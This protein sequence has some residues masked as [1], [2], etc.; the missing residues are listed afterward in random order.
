M[1]AN[2]ANLDGA[3][4]SERQFGVA[5]LLALATLWCFFLRNTFDPERSFAIDMDNEFFIGTVLSAISASLSHGEWPLRMDTVLGGVPL[6]NFPQLSPLYPF[7]LASL[8][9]FRTPDE[10]VHSMHWITLGHLLILEINTFVFLRVIGASRIAA[11]AGA[12]LFAFSANSLTYAAWLNITAPY[13][14]FPLYLAGLVGIFRYPDRVA[15]PVLALVAIVLLTLASP[16]Q[17]LIHAVMVSAVF[18]IARWTSNGPVEG[19][20][21]IRRPLTLLVMVGVLAFLIVAPVI[22]P[23]AA[24]FKDMVR[25]IGP[26]PPVVGNARIP[27]AAFQIDQLSV[28]S[29]I[30]IFFRQDGAAVGSPYVGMFG[31]ALAAVAA[32]SCMR[33]WIA[34]ALLFIAVYSIVSSTGSNLGLVHVNYLIPVLNKIREPSRFLVLFQFAIAALAALGIDQLRRAAQADCGLSAQSSRRQI[35]ALWGVAALGLTLLLVSD[36]TVISAVPPWASVLSLVIL[37]VLTTLWR[38]RPSNF[39]GVVVGSL[40]AGVA[41]LLLAAD[42]RWV[43]APIAVSKYNRSGGQELDKVFDRLVELDPQRQFRVIFDGMIDKQMASMQASYKRI[44]TLNA[45]F[46]PAPYRQFEELY[47]HGQRS[48]NYFQALGARYLV[49]DSCMA[50]AVRGYEFLERIG[51]LNIYEATH[52]LPHSQALTTVDGTYTDVH[53]FAA[54]LAGADLSK[55][56]LYVHASDIDAF[57][58]GPQG[59]CTSQ[60]TRRSAER[61]RVTTECLSRSALILN[62]FFDGSWKAKVDGR[63]ARILRVNG[64]QMAVPVPPGKHVVDVRYRP[65]TFLTSVPIAIVGAVLACFALFALLR[66]GRAHP[67][68]PGTCIKTTAKH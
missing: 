60:E 13:A 34:R 42:V 61:L 38:R 36:G 21:T 8:P 3:T 33:S 47:Y 54:Q 41:L 49:C 29:L 6:Y 4:N 19:W 39:A 67:P 30:G 18:V 12:A 2:R 11:I 27:F 10:V 16:A 23:A 35:A 31:I 64:S 68:Q 40:W 5:A 17:P 14:W 22:I 32:I 53:D 24:E 44:R 50:D 63:Q 26:F 58:T 59:G 1:L 55:G 45:Y 20:K 15:F 56:L 28:A 25:W 9:I 43:P 57:G 7:Y 48:P 62:E 46:N 52:A 66:R 51:G 37:I 65:T